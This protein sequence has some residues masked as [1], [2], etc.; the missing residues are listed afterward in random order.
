MRNFLV[1]GM[2]QSGEGSE[3]EEV[4]ADLFCSDE[5]LFALRR[6]DALEALSPG[7]SKEDFIS[8]AIRNLFCLAPLS[9]MGVFKESPFGEGVDFRNVHIKTKD[10]CTIGAWLVT[11]KSAGWRGEWA[12][13]LHGNGTNRFVFSRLYKVERLL[14]EG[15]SLLIPDYRGFGDS[16]GT[17][18]REGF[19]MDVDACCM[20]LEKRGVREIGMVGFSLGTAIALEYLARRHPKPGAF[21]G[22]GPQDKL[23]IGK[24]VLVSPFSSTTELLKEYKMWKIVQRLVPDS[25]DKAMQGFGYD[26]IKNIKKVCAEILILHGDSDWVIPHTHGEALASAAECTIEIY[27]NDTHNS[28]LINPATWPR[29]TRFLR[30][31][32]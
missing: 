21:G 31:L 1:W 16:E 23:R 28:I 20:Y 9:Y 7:A 5:T 18:C 10:A 22:G 14:D 32:G 4:S 25:E 19:V 8:N 3:D 2:E 29:I 6:E 30:G 27:S 13:V 26:S 24:L 11:K 15:M 12:V 17:A